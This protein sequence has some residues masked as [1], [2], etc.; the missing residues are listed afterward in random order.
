MQKIVS[1]DSSVDKTN[2]IIKKILA[3]ENNIIE[4]LNEDEEIK[5]KLYDNI[6]EILIDTNQY[7]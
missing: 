5:Y 7:L 4:N 2:I 3:D 6:I 1:I